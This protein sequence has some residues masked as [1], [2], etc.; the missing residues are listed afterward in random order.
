MKKAG[1][2]ASGRVWIDPHAA[3]RVSVLTKTRGRILIDWPCGLPVRLTRNVVT[4]ACHHVDKAA[5]KA[6][7]QARRDGRAR[8]HFYRAHYHRGMGLN[9]VVILAGMN[10]NEKDLEI[11]LKGLAR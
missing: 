6:K 4:L 10:L 5:A 2:R 1:A 9:P 7:A 11:L 3:V 8:Q